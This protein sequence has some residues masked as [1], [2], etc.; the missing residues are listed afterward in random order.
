MIRA[1]FL[2]SSSKYKQLLLLFGLFSLFNSSDMF[3][4]LALKEKGFTTS[5]T[6]LHYIVFNLSFVMLS[7]P[8]GILSDKMDRMKILII[9]FLLFAVTYFILAY[10]NAPF[11]TYIAFGIYGMYNASTDGI[12]KAIVGK[13]IKTEHK[14]TALGLLGMIQSIM[15]L[16]S[17]IIAGVLW[18]N[19]GYI[20]A[21]L[22]SALGIVTTA[23]IF[24]GYYLSSFKKR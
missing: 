16:L 6:I 13:E 24:L 18:A 8:I 21:L 23:L 17:S 7:W 11:F 5:A 2:Q 4:I 20:I 19:C 1:F 9:G 15:M 3:L 10:C 14:A 22:F 12:S